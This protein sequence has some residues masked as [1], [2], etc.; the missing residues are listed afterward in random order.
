MRLPCSCRTAHLKELSVELS[1]ASWRPISLSSRLPCGLLFRRICGGIIRTRRAA[2]STAQK[3]DQRRRSGPGSAL[4]RPHANFHGARPRR[5][6]GGGARDARRPRPRSG[7]V[8]R[9]KER[10]ELT[11]KTSSTKKSGE[12]LQYP[13]PNAARSE[14]RDNRPYTSAPRS[15]AYGG[16][17]LRLVSG[18]R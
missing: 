3:M 5:Q 13:R 6:L 15:A 10:R 7:A 16:L 2:Q 11:H 9:A 12:M 17:A 8:A 4:D 1:L 18:F 14:L